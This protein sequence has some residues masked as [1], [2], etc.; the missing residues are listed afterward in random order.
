[1]NGLPI[2]LTFGVDSVPLQVDISDTSGFKILEKIVKFYSY[3]VILI[4]FLK[5]VESPDCNKWQIFKVLEK[6]KKK[7]KTHK[8]LFYAVLSKS[9]RFTVYFLQEIS[10]TFSHLF[11]SKIT[12]GSNKKLIKKD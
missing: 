12:V 2:F 3:C 1:M 6:V 8:S 5:S 10:F 4:P 9:I 11:P 7:K